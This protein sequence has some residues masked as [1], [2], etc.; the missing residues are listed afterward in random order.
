[1]R[2]PHLLLAFALGVAALGFVSR[3]DAAEY[4]FSTYGLGS[5]AFGAGATPPP[6]TYV[7]TVIGY[8]SGETRATI[9]FGG[10]IFTAGAKAK[11][12][13]SALSGL[14]V[15]EATLFGGK[16]GIALTIPAGH[17]DITAGITGPG[18]ATLTRQTDGWG[19]GDINGRIQLGWQSGTFAHLI[20]VQGVAPTGRYKVGFEP[21][22][23]LHRP[24]ID[25]GWSFTWEEPT[26]K[27]QF[28]GTFGFTFN[29][30]NDKTD[31]QSGHEFHFEWA[32]GKE[33]SQRLVLGI[34]GYNYRQL[35]GDSGSGARL[36][37]YKGS[38]DA[39]GAGAVY[40][41]IVGTTPLIFNLRH[42]E[43]FDPR[44]RMDGRMTIFTGT[45]KF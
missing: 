19:L 24:G 43:E 10:Q 28:N 9:D 22:V 17:V 35:D 16:V 37:P 25:T 13:Q 23:G 20:Y 33:V 44:N 11:F 42:Y 45:L 40:T 38:V 39:I 21:I 29:F 36:G 5:S 12:F 7:T 18:G 32:V 26:S 2:K 6:G 34:V 41:T 31:Y 14:Y 27:F 4:G 15:P 3:A 1:M 8:Y 30:E